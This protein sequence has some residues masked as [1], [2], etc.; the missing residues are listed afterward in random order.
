MSSTIQMLN[1]KGLITPPNWLPDN[2]MYETVMGS[3][4]YGVSG[5]NSDIDIYGFC[6]PRKNVIFPHYDGV[7]YG[8]DKNYEKFE[9][10]QQHHVKD[11]GKEYDMSIYNIVKYFSLCSE[12]NPNMLDSLFTPRRCVLHSTKVGEMVRENRKLFLHK[13]CFYKFKGYAYSQIN[14]MKS[15]EIRNWID[16]CNKHCFELDTEIDEIETAFNNGRLTKEEFENSKKIIKR[17][18]TSGKRSKRMYSIQEYGYDTKFAYHLVRL[19]LECEQILTEGD[20]DLERNREQL[21]SIR[22]GKWEEERVLKFFEEKELELEKL[23]N[24]SKVIPYKPDIPKIKQLL[25]DCLEEHYGNL[26]NLI[27]KDDSVYINTLKEID[28]LLHEVIHN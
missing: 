16:F 21:K 7:I 20:L 13:G 9:Q 17:I 12:N 3:I 6:I 11:N 26:G 18:E 23:Y 27:K 25:I 4:S 24:S 2:V 10:F 19:L 8:F 15:K 22:K 14:K 28:K 1:K 5:D